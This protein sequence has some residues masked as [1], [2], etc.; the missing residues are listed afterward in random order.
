MRC[1]R[2]RNVIRLRLES[3]QLL[4]SCVEPATFVKWLDGL[5][6]ALAVAHD[7]DER[8]FPV[9]QSVPRSQ[10]SRLQRA[11]AQR[12][13]PR[14]RY[15]VP[16]PRPLDQLRLNG[17]STSSL[18][19]GIEV[20]AGMFSAFSEV[21]GGP[22]LGRRPY[23]PSVTSSLTSLNHDGDI[24]I[25]IW[26][27]PGSQPPIPAHSVA[28]LHPMRSSSNS[29]P[30]STSATTPSSSLSRAPSLHPM[31]RRST[32]STTHRPPTSAATP[33]SEISRPGTSGTGMPDSPSASEFGKWRPSHE[34]RPPGDDLRYARLCYAILL[35]SSPRKSDYIIKRQTKWH[36]DWESGRMTRALPP[37]Y[38]DIGLAEY[39]RM[40]LRAKQAL[41]PAASMMVTN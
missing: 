25:D 7:I 23:A 22:E 17:S 33:P 8:D 41:F 5:F 16:T 31:N 24:D 13:P 2:R 12:A 36:V 3:D 38:K 1:H 29:S 26:P 15:L 20:P 4:M 18:D 21:R 37:L 28:A 19:G 11:Q 32:T 39:D 14:Q 34:N 30:A 10:R 40:A 35:F 9:D 6:A 27:F